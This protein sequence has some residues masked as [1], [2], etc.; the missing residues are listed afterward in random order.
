MLMAQLRGKLPSELWMGSEDLLTS[1]V[2]GTL[3]YSSAVMVAGL[4]DRARPLE[5][6]PPPSLIGPITWHFWPWWDTC[7]PDVV[8][9][10]EHNLCVVEAK[11]Y[12]EFGVSEIIGHQLR[13]EWRDGLRRAK[14]TG[15]T[16]WLVAVT[17][18][19]ADPEAIM[20]YQLDGSGAE[21]TRVCWLSWSEIGRFL[22]AHRDES[23]L[24][25]FD[26]LLEILSRMGLAPFS[27]F[28]DLVRRCRGLLIAGLPWTD[29]LDLGNLQQ[30][31]TVG[32]TPTL[33]MAS[34]LHGIP[35]TLWKFRLDSTTGG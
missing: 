7:E 3:K 18:H 4:L 21:L 5:D 16:L 1:A 8:I 33:K 6:G 24:A 12:A 32:F 13:R 22:Q 34:V 9:E 29:R 28:S 27:G 10:D 14:E 26:D 19:G 15:K 31:K 11:L 25:V 23:S 30:P 35:H 17:N 20:R 2:F